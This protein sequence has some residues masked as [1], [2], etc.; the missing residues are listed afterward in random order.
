MSFKIAT[1]SKMPHSKLNK[2]CARLVFR[3]SNTFKNI[4]ELNRELDTPCSWMEINNIL[5]IQIFP[6]CSID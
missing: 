6:K 4:K 2:T 5:K 1:K 3:K